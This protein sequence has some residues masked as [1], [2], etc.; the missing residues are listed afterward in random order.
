MMKGILYTSA[1]L[2]KAHDMDTCK[3]GMIKGMEQIVEINR[4]FCVQ[5]PWPLTNYQG[6]SRL[7]LHTPFF[8]PVNFRYFVSSVSCAWFMLA[9]VYYCLVL[10][11]LMSSD[12]VVMQTSFKCCVYICV[13]VHVVCPVW[14][15]F[16][17][18]WGGGGG[19]CDLH[20]Y[21]DIYEAV[22]IWYLIL[23]V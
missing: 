9:Y 10:S 4:K 6:A 21:D 15:H 19:D 14:Q 17:W 8:G 22:I 11:L 16:N 7:T 18:K 3:M 1:N 13:C 20:M 12:S 5:L 2:I 23:L